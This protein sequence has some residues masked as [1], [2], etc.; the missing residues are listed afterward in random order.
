MRLGIFGGT[1]DP[2]HLG[3]LIVAQDACSALTLDGVLFVLAASPP[4]K[5]GRAHTPADIRLEMVQAATAGDPRLRPC[6]I[7]LCRDGPSYTVDTLRQLAAENP[8]A[9]LFLLI[10]AD[11]AREFGTW[12]APDEIAALATVVA[13]SRE[14]EAAPPEPALP[15]MRWLPVTRIDVSATDIRRRVAAGEP[16]RY[17]V[18]T[19]VEAI[20]RREGLYRTTESQG[21]AVTSGTAATRP[22]GPAESR[23]AEDRADVAGV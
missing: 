22:G 3:H 21:Q 19:A 7:E 16:I 8:A 1:F 5:Q 14:G 18:P 15:W 13:L 12:R 10:G 2:P 4:H 6:D 20:I 9:E 11:Q 23:P 17:L